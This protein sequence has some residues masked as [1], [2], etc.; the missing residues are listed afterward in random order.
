MPQSIY[1]LDANVFIQAKNGPYRFTLVPQFWAFLSQQIDSGVI[2][3]PKIVFDELIDGKDDLA[4]WIKP[5]KQN[6]LCHH[7]SQTVQECYSAV[8]N[9]VALNFKPHQAAEFLFG[10]DG[11]LIAHAMDGDGV[12]VTQESDRSHKAKIKI[13]TMCKVF[14][15][16]CMNTYE[17]LAALKAK[18]G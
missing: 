16:R 11:W 18:L 10:A 12:V 17:M 15:V 9:H 14:H 6:G 2:R 1:W 7:A 4:T 8:A 13:P 3:S 5:R